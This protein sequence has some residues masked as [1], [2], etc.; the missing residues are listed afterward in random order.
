MT[1]TQYEAFLKTVELGSLT[2]AAMELDYTQS[3]ITHM[4]NALKQDCGMQLLIRDRTGVRLTT[5]GELLLPYMREVCS[6]QRRF[7]DQLKSMRDLESGL[8][9]IGTFVSVSAQ[10]LPGMLR[11]FRNDY[12]GIEFELLH[13]TNA[14]NE[15]WT[16]SGRVDLS[17][18]KLP[19][20]QPLKTVFL[21]R[22]PLVVVLP[23]NHICAKKETFPIKELPNHA[24]IHL[25]DGT[26]NE[27]DEL[28]KH[29]RVYPKLHFSEVDDYAILAMV[30]NEL[31]ISV[32]PE[33]V[34]EKTARR[35]VSMP[36]D[37]PAYRDL[38]I[39]VNEKKELSAAAKH[40]L[41]YVQDW[42]RAN[43]SES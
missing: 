19:A 13:G 41:R 3:G 24:Y 29:Y 43:Y 23:Q 34:L 15:V 4:L 14:E 7:S 36:L 12:P 42:I 27:I 2:R 26:E 37:V 25:K 1:L 21:H 31:G 28:L 5:E 17:F 8:V 9:R 39:A 38:G 16:M 33:L 30:E 11:S 6:S 10:W 22:D 32:L 35:I 20:V 18:I 40:F